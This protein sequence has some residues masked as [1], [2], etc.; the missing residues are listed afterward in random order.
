MGVERR[1]RP[2]TTAWIGRQ[3]IVSMRKKNPNKRDECRGS[4]RQEPADPVERYHNVV[5]DL[6]RWEHDHQRFIFHGDESRRRQTLV[7]SS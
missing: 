1:R 2:M 3:T 7:V 5:T 6:R 4:G